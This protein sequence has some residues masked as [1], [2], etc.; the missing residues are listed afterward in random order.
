MGRQLS[1]RILETYDLEKRLSNKLRNASVEDRKHLYITT[2]DEY[3][4]TIDPAP[5][6]EIKEEK[7]ATDRA[8]MLSKFVRGNQSFADI[9]SGNCRLAL[10]ISKIVEKCY[11]IDVYEKIPD[12][13]DI[14]KNFEFVQADG[15]NIPLPNGSIDFACSDQ[16]LEHLHPE[17]ALEHL[18]SVFRALRKNGTYLVM[19]PHSFSGPH[20]ISKYFDAEPTGFHLKEYTNA[21]LVKALR[22]TGFSDVFAIIGVRGMVFGVVS[23]KWII[24]IEALLQAL[25]TR[26]R[27][28][29]TSWLPFRSVLG[30]KVLAKK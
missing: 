8:Q 14:P 7:K 19:T 5:T 17:D 11:A 24:K 28:A 12:G 29:V 4:R 10:A 1:P 15:V 30:I 21:E 6:Q 25:P 20:D 18:K 22:Q 26:A 23:I 3:F 27:R 13:L 9:G 16:L 2:Y